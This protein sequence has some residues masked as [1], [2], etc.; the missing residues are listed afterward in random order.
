MKS[1]LDVSVSWWVI[2]KGAYL[3]GRVTWMLPGESVEI[4]AVSIPFGK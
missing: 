2:N 4:D 1:L 3:Q